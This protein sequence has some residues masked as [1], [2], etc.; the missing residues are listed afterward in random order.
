MMGGVIVASIGGGRLV[1]HTGHYKLLV[2]AGLLAAALSFATLAWSAWTGGGAAMGEVILAVLGLG[3]GVSFP[4]LTTAIQNAVDRADLGTAT[5]MAAF[6]RSLGGAVGVAM[7][8][9]ILTARLQALMPGG[10]RGVGIGTSLPLADHAAVVF[11]YR[12]A[13]A[14]TFLAGGGVAAIACIVVALS[15]ERPLAMTWRG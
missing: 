14:T 15:P 12:H 9:A 8:G 11:A 13:L 6:F 10:L 5:A 2:T 7:S 3:I 1:S 4:N